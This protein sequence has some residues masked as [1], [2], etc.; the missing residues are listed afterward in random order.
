MK[1]DQKRYSRL[2]NIAKSPWRASY[3]VSSS[4]WSAQWP[5]WLF[6]TLT[7]SGWVFYQNFS[8]QQPNGLKC[9][10]HLESDDL[11]HFTET[12][13]GCC[14][15]LLWTATVP[16][17]LLPCSLTTSSFLYWQ[18]SWWEL[19]APTRQNRCPVRQIRQ[20]SKMTRS[21]LSNL[22]KRLTTSAI[23]RFSTTKG[24]SAPHQDKNLDKAMSSLQGSW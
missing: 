13:L 22:L 12:G 10:V 20:A 3:H 21:W 5:Q 14:Q 19:G 16:T 17:W 11:V 15:I 18:C 7:A 6:L 9:W 4:N 24:N 8:F 1:T 2:K 23:R